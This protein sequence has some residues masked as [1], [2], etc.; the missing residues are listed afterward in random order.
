MLRR[1][2]LLLL[3]LLP[4]AAAP[5]QGDAPPD[6]AV[7]K[8]RLAA[9]ARLTIDGAPTTRTGPL[10]TFI[11]DPMKPGAVYDYELKATWEV[12]GRKR[13]A[14]KTIQVRPG[15][16]YEVDLTRAEPARVPAGTLLSE[17]GSLWRQSAPGQPWQVV[18]QKE[19][20]S[21]GD[22]YVGATDAAFESKDGAVR[23]AIVGDLNRDSPFPIL[24]TGFSLNPPDGVDLD[25]S[26]DRGRLDLT[27]MKKEGPATVRVRVRGHVNELV[28]KTPGTRVVGEIYGRWLRNQP[29]VKEPKPDDPGPS[30]AVVVLVIKGEA[31][32]KGFRRDYSLA[33]PPGPALLLGGDVTQ[34]A[35]V[36]QAIDKLPDWAE[37]KDNEKARAI[38][39]LLGR[40]RKLTIDKGV[41]AA[42]DEFLGSA[43]A[44]E[45]RLGLVMAGA[46]DELP[47]AAGLM[48]TTKDLDTWEL[49]VVVLRTWIGRGPGQDQALYKALVERRF[50]PHEAEIILHL[51]HGLSDEELAWPETYQVLLKYMAGD[52]LF[53]RGLAHW[54]LCCLAP[55]GRAFGFQPN[56]AP[57]EREKALAK[58]R[59]LIKPGQLPPKPKAEDGK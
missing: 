55:Q 22:L 52:R 12:N 56:A 5:G 58:W 23:V 1:T 35:A 47:R 46:F 49:A 53:L 26:L 39:A 13:S 18:K 40:F 37:G 10:R 50:E 15:M 34:S 19:G 14:V 16:V 3:A 25:I 6:R 45:Q 31:F 27:N 54:H 11:S 38:R 32:I 41:M 7:L 2:P 8:V 21:T 24:E 30:L 20:L 17:D 4:P 48:A 33:E 43:D 36:P 51:L 29:F 28:L 9:D 57:E 44:G 59:D 42:L